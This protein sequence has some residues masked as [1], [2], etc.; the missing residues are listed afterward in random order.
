MSLGNYECFTLTDKL[1]IE[2]IL[3]EIVILR[4]FG[5]RSQASSLSYKPRFELFMANIDSKPPEFYSKHVRNLWISTSDDPPAFERILS[6]CSGVENL[7]LFS[8]RRS[9]NLPFIPFLEIPNAVSHLRRLTCKLETLFPPWSTMQNFQHP[10]FANLTHLHLYDEM[11]DWS[12]YTGFENLR[13]LSHLAFACCGPEALATVMPKLP[14]IEY[15]ALGHYGTDEGVLSVYRR[16]PVEVYGIKVVWIDGLGINDWE[17]G[18]T[19]R[20][21]F[22]DL[23]EQEVG[24]RRAEMV[25]VHTTFMCDKLVLIDNC[26]PLENPFF[27]F[28]V[29]YRPY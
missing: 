8:N 27:F 10:F 19:G 16:V 23:V 4:N 18:A 7:V 2:P 1:R 17:G 6:V 21:D 24:R 25:R 29:S 11:E 22:W 15:V 3:Y 14:A 9:I 26:R 28:I 5:R 13:S 20:A 12:T